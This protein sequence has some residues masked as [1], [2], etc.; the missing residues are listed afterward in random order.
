MGEEGTRNTRLNFEI[1]T[2]ESRT[3][4]N[5]IIYQLVKLLI[6]HR[7]FY[8]F[9]TGPFLNRILNIRTGRIASLI[10]KIVS[11]LLSLSPVR[12]EYRGVLLLKFNN[13]PE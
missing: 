6:D 7:I 9:V 13:R 10:I 1:H 8:F 3:Q 4:F 5:D 11:L 2:T 12:I